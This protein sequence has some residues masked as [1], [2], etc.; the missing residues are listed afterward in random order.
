MDFLALKDIAERDLELVNPISPDKVVRAGE[1]AGL[2]RGSRVVEYGCGYGE[3]LALWAARFGVSGLGIDFRPKACERARQKMAARNLAARIEI[4]CADA[5]N[6]PVEPGGYDVAA[7]VGASFIWD[8]FR[9]ALQQMRL[10]L[11]PGGRIVIGEPYWRSAAV[12]PEYSRREA[13][14]HT[15]FELSQILRA[16]GYDLEYVVRAS[17]DDWDRYEAGN[18]QGLVRW[19]QENPAHP[20]RGEVIAHLRE[21][22]DEYLRYGREHFGWALYVLGEASA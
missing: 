2:K 12:P 4:A 10:A 3:V 6:Y 13:A 15:E 7:C 16:E 18:W 8:G 21:T 14:I 19:L 9:S 20:E 22:Q 11:R 1:A 17:Q 5:A